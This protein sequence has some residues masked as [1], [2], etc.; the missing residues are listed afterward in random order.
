MKKNFFIPAVLFIL[1]FTAPVFADEILC[2]A[3]WEPEIAFA[4]SSLVINDDG[5][6]TNDPPHLQN[7]LRHNLPDTEFGTVTVR[8]IKYVH[9]SRN[10]LVSINVILTENV[11]LNHKLRIGL[12]ITRKSNTGQSITIFQKVL[13]ANSRNEIEQFKQP[14]QHIIQTMQPILRTELRPTKIKY[15]ITKGKVQ[16]DPDHTDLEIKIEEIHDKYGAVGLDP[17]GQKLYCFSSKAFG[18]TF[19]YDSVPTAR[20]E[21]EVL[22]KTQK[23][24]I[25]NK[26]FDSSCFKNLYTCRRPVATVETK[27]TKYFGIPEQ[28][29]LENIESEKETITIACPVKIEQEPVIYLMPGE[30]KNIS[31]RALDYKDK[32]IDGLWFDEIK[33]TPASLGSLNQSKDVTREDGYNRLLK[34]TAADTDSEIRGEVTS[35]VCSDTSPDLLGLDE[36]NRPVYWDIL[37]KQKVIVSELPTIEADIY[38]EQRLSRVND[39]KRKDKYGEKHAHQTQST[40]QIMK[41]NVKA[42]FDKRVFHPN[43]KDDSGFMG[44]LIEYSGAG[45]ATISASDPRPS[46]QLDFTRGWFDTQKCGRQTYD[47]RSLDLGHIFTFPNAP[48]P[49][50]VYYRHFIPSPNSPIK[51]HP[52]EGLSFLEKNALNAAIKYRMEGYSQDHEMNDDSC[53]LVI[54]KNPLSTATVPMMLTNYFPMPIITYFDDVYGFEEAT[55]AL[56]ENETAFLRK[57]KSDG[58]AFDALNVE[59]QISLGRDDVA[60]DWS[61]PEDTVEEKYDPQLNKV[62]GTFILRSNA[63]IL[64]GKFDLGE[65]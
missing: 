4:A 27:V 24:E 49:V 59:K 10:T 48:I 38:S 7:W 37:I 60:E 50:Y 5:S 41:L 20:S 25:D 33:L 29:S 11:E 26:I 46:S 55:V 8:N 63:K 54:N 45:Q 65:R 19:I 17:E 43:Y 34:L 56:K 62:Y 28:R 36:N 44:K 64:R 21:Q 39:M 57:L 53:Q 47:Y 12:Q 61:I 31:V 52:T 58:T 40:K 51:N 6:A 22:G 9:P 1:I 14:L 13:T 16:R 15:K 42:K 23:I 18:K 30:V 2:D 3:T 35:K 32:P